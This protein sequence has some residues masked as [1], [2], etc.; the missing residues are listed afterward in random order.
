MVCGGQYWTIWK[1]ENGKKNKTCLRMTVNDEPLKVQHL[2][3]SCTFK[4]M[5]MGSQCLQ[6]QIICWD[7][8]SPFHFTKI[9]I[10]NKSDREIRLVWIWSSPSILWGQLWATCSLFILKQSWWKC[11]YAAWVIEREH[12]CSVRGREKQLFSTAV[13]PGTFQVG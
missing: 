10:W 13:T 6:M 8:F 1:G 7:F 11:H 3:F 5:V 12:P 4:E 2:K 9:S